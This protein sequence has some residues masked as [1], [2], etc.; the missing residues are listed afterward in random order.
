MRRQ[1]NGR[2]AQIVPSRYNANSTIVAEVKSGN[3]VFDHN[4]SS[5]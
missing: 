3:N 2:V 5:R 4:L 1:R